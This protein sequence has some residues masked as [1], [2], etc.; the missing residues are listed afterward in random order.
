M[1]GYTSPPLDPALFGEQWRGLWRERLEYSGFW[2]GHWLAHQWRDAYW[3][4]GFVAENFAAIECPVSAGN[5]WADG[6]TNEV[7]RLMRELKAPHRGLIGPWGHHTPHLGLPALS[8]GFLQECLHR[9]DTWLTGQ[10]TGILNEPMLR[11]WMQDSVPPSHAYGARP[12]HWV[13]ESRW[14]SPNIEQLHYHWTPGRL[15]LRSRPAA[16]KALSIQSPLSVALFAKPWCSFCATPD[17]P[18]DQRQEDDDA[19][20]F[21][22][23][24]LTKS[25]EILST[26]SLHLD[27]SANRA[28]AILAVGLS[29]V[30]PDDKITCV[31]YG[32]LN[33]THHDSDEHPKSLM[34]GVR[35]RVFIRVNYI[36]H[37]FP[38]HHRKNRD[39]DLVLADRL[40]AA[41]AGETDDLH[42]R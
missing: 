10:D 37:A 2:L 12:G 40:A 34:P 21:D 23:A 30:A 38:K 9:R 25:M 32:L 26:P 3:K 19:L 11:A 4:H 35:Y 36:A 8:I 5:G 16:E 24:L 6:D 1:L 18:H 20:V 15:A 33:L 22:R 13:G 28:M 42:R 41:G 31:T 27:V 29:D 14:L 39:L 7:F 17:L